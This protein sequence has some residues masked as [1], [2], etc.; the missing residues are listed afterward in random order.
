MLMTELSRHICSI[1]LNKVV[2]DIKIIIPARSGSKGWPNKNITLFDCTVSKI[3]DKYRKHVVISTDSEI[4]QEMATDHNLKV[5]KRSP[6]ISADDTDIK[7]TLISTLS[8]ENIT[9]NTIVIVLYLTYPTRKWGDV[10]DMYN[11]FIST[12]AKSMLCGQPALTHPCL[13]MLEGPG[14]TGEQVYKHSLYQR[15]QYPEVFEI[16]HYI[17]MFRRGELNK[18][19]KNMYNKRTKYYRIDRVIDVDTEEDFKNYIKDEN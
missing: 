14:G 6:D 9:N 17:Y 11:H 13:T 10:E 1:R 12:N 2:S 16:S 15:Q 19:G 8:G 7:T 18:L 4:I 5:Y 3:P